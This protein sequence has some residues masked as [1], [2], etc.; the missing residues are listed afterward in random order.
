M[1]LNHHQS[2][3]SFH[4]ELYSLVPD[5]HL[6]DSLP[7]SSQLSQFRR[8]RLGENQVEKVLEHIVK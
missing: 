4:S 8:Q 7:D 5:Y 6:E 1:L 3:L 2:S